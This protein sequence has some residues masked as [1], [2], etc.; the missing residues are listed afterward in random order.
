MGYKI[1][2]Q[3]LSVMGYLTKISSRLGKEIAYWRLFCGMAISGVCIWTLS[4]LC[5]RSNSVVSTNIPGMWAAQNQH[6]PCS[7]V[8]YPEKNIQ[9]ERPRQ[10]CPD[11]CQGK[12]IAGWRKTVA[13]NVWMVKPEVNGWRR[14]EISEPTPPRSVRKRWW[15][16]SK[17][18]RNNTQPLHGMPLALET[19]MKC[20]VERSLS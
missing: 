12:K 1:L 13:V 18:P 16:V 17:T 2:A 10:G 15:L 11:N 9:R 5:Y 14:S 19:F 7:I 20:H 3:V 8:C 4:S 6:K